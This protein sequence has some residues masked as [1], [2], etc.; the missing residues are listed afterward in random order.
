MRVL[1]SIQGHV[2]SAT[3]KQAK[4]LAEHLI[5]SIG[6]HQRKRI[7]RIDGENFKPILRKVAEDL[8]EKGYVVSA[9]YLSAGE[10]ALKQ[11][12]AIAILDPRNE[13]AISD[14]LDPFW[15]AQILH[16]QGYIAF[17][18]ELVGQYIHHL[19]LDPADVMMIARLRV[20]Y[21]YTTNLIKSVFDEVDDHFFPSNIPDSRLVCMHCGISNEELLSEAQYPAR[22]VCAH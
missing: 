9:D 11:Y 20:L 15:H 4:P 6:P 19:P 13:H 14:M 1:T 2:L 8:S 17:C 22:F 18:D 16:T 5:V 7:E 3:V 12:H 21:P 10:F